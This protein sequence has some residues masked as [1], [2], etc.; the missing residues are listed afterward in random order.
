MDMEKMINVIKRSGAPTPIDFDKIETTIIRACKGYEADVSVQRIIDEFHRLVYDGLKTSEI[1]Q[2]LILAATAFIEVDPAYSFVASRLLWQRLYKSVFGRSVAQDEF[3]QAYRD[4]FVGEIKRG[5]AAGYLDER[6]LL[7]DLDRLAAA[8]RPERDDLIGYQ[9]AQTLAS[10]YFMKI[11][12]ITLETPQAF[13]MRV[14]MGLSLLEQNK[15]GQALAFYEVLSTLRYTPSTPTLFHA[16][17]VHAQLSSCYLSTVD[18]NLHHIFKFIGDNAQLAKWAGGIG[19]D[20]TRIRATGSWIASIHAY[21]QGV[22]PFM[23]IANDVVVAITRSGIRRGGTVGYL[24]TWHYDVED[25]FD[26]RRNT[27]D[28]RRRT[29]DMNTANW[30]PDLFMK[31]VVADGSWTLLCPSEAPDLH[32]LYGAAFEKRYEEYEQLAREGKMKLVK[33]MP[34]RQLWRKMLSRL[35]ETGH[36]WITFKDA[37]NIRSPQDHVG[38]VHSSNL[39]TE[40]TLNTSN[41]ETAVCNLGSVNLQKHVSKGKLDKELL[42]DTVQHALRMLDNV[43]DLNFYPT[44]EAKNSNM[45]HR[46][47]GLGVMG[48]QDLLYMLDVPFEDEQALEL[49][50]SIQELISYNAILASSQLAQEKGAYSTFKGSKWDRGQLPIDTLDLLEQERGSTVEVSRIQRLDWQYLRDHIKQWGMRNS[51]TM[52]IAPTATISTIVGCYPSIEPIYK[53]IYVKANVSGEFTIANTYLVEDLKKLGMWDSE[54]IEQLK[55]FDG[56]LDAIAGVPDHL[57]RKYKSAFDIDQT[58]LIK[59]TAARGKWIDQ[60]QS[61]N[62]FMKGV[63]GTQLNEIYMTAW[64]CGLKTTYYLRTLGASQIEK[65][66]LDAKKYGFTQKREYQK[67]TQAAAIAEAQAEEK[68]APTAGAAC[69]LENTADCESCQ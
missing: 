31:R 21:S 9:G 52:A 24:E 43:I 27:G 5:V 51:N 11:E 1:E 60:A 66:T 19:N 15:E 49:A 40:I 36:P 29:H 38:V 18:D 67:I 54:M 57:K 25:F 33:T 8:L 16:G 55:Y 12:G 37:C 13:W 7:F 20:W 64:R 30:I 26:L 69:G 44:A 3:T 17:M 63:S 56:S 4:A 6:M 53:N 68:K 41:D 10:R 58:W 2:A 28:E 46:P 32:D 45:R 35:F 47:V 14:A 22:I 65:S 42:A 50:D 59:L 48:F 61:H 62:V 34:A 23:K 39:C